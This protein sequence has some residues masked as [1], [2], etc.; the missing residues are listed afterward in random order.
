MRFRSLSQAGERLDHHRAAS[1]ANPSFLFPVVAFPFPA[2]A[3]RGYSSLS[4]TKRPS[5]PST[6]SPLTLFLRINDLAKN[7]PPNLQSK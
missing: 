2:R 5:E 6:P 4:R 3:E 1:T 7:S